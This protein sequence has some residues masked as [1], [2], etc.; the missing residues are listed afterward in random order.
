MSSQPFLHNPT[1]CYVFASQPGGQGCTKKDCKLR[2][3]VLKCLCGLVL[4]ISDYASHSG[5]KRHQDAMNGKPLRPR[6]TS[7]RIG[8]GSKRAH[9]R[10]LPMR[11][12]QQQASANLYF[13]SDGQSVKIPWDEDED[14]GRDLEWPTITSSRQMKSIP[15]PMSMRCP[16]CSREVPTAQ[17]KDHVEGKE[18]VDFGVVEEGEEPMIKLE[19]PRECEHPP[20]P[21]VLSK[22]R[23][24]SSTRRD[25]YGE[26][27]PRVLVVTF[28]PSYAGRYEDV[29]ELVF[30]DRKLR[31]CFV[32]HRRVSSTYK[33]TS[34]NIRLPL[35]RMHDAVT[36]KYDPMR[37]LFPGPEHVS[38]MRR[39]TRRPMDDIVPINRFV[40]SDP[41]QLETVA[42][43]VNMPS[44]S[45][46]FVVFGP[47]GTGKTATLVEA[48]RQLLALDSS[49]RILDKLWN[50]YARRDQAAFKVKSILKGTEYEGSRLWT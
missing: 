35:R 5:G 6:T 25:S 13:S 41:E 44:G 31:Q 36:K 22:C 24:L 32:I 28:P 21:L 11:Q 50:L 19:I 46:P 16:K 3:D 42:A 49:N 9:S 40:G 7:N 34:F 43:I 17:Y 20:P 37:F 29:I 33:G 2:H 30:W 15:M 1:F 45:P 4:P 47:P 23:M 12:Q 14:D 38:N 26:R 8:P 27:P 48:L 10:G 39:V 18:G